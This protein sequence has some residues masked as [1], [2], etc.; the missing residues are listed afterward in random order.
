MKTVSM[1]WNVNECTYKGQL[2]DVLVQRRK[3]STGDEHVQHCVLLD[4]LHRPLMRQQSEVETIYLQDFVMSSKTSSSRWRILVYVCDVDALIRV[5][6][7][8]TGWILINTA[9][10]LETDTVG[11]VPVLVD[12]LFLSELNRD[13][14][15]LD[16]LPR[17]MAV[18]CH[19][20]GGR[21]AR[22]AFQLVN[23][24]IVG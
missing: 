12:R 15:A 17:R 11:H 7:W 2:K 20:T 24:E 14:E 16:T 4:V 3:F 23:S 8:S 18:R 6:E 22:A 5:S 21:A 1:T 19:E 13:A 9:S 10:N